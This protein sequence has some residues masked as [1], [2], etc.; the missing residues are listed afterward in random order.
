MDK[1]LATSDQNRGKRHSR[2]R[3]SCSGDL[4]D[5]PSE[6]LGIE[7]PDRGQRHQ[8]PRRRTE[9]AKDKDSPVVQD[10]GGMAKNIR[11]C[12][13]CGKRAE[14]GRVGVEVKVVREANL[15]PVGLLAAND[16]H[17]SGEV[18]GCRVPDAAGGLS[19]PSRKLGDE[20]RLR[21]REDVYEDSGVV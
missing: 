8:R 1:N 19:C 10:Y 3:E 4:Y 21:A 17:K 9:A 13:A 12:V 14:G 6:G 18:G 5:G 7:Y 11:W 2:R 15:R 20:V 16:E